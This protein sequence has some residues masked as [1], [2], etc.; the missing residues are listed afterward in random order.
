MQ[1]RMIVWS[2]ASGFFRSPHNN[3]P[4]RK[5]H[6]KPRPHYAGSD[7]GRSQESTCCVEHQTSP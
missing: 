3:R 5:W 2:L 4:Q 1:I 7:R 6:Q